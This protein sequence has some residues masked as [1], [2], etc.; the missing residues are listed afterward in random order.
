MRHLPNILVD[1]NLEKAFDFIIVGAGIGGTVVASRLHERD[2]SL[3]IL[4]IEAGPDSSKTELA[5]VTMSPMKVA[6]LKGS[7]L[8]WYYE[9]VPQKNLDGLKIY[10][11]AG[12]AIG[13]GSVINYG[14][15]FGVV[16]R[17]NC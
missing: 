11:G 1:G 17:S 13:G 7:E 3:S 6:L 9:T 14:M 15:S 12:K 2:P 16:K 8:D 10:V 4:L 5:E